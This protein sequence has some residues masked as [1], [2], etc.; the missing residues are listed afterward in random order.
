[1]LEKAYSQKGVHI[2]GN[3]NGW[4][5]IAPDQFLPIFIIATLVLIFGVAYAAIITL[6]KMKY[7][8]KKW[9]PLGYGFW[10][11]QTLSLYKLAILIHSNHYTTKVLL[12]TMVAYLFVPHLYFFLISESDKRYEQSDNKDS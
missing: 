4:P 1:M 3:V 10:G 12:V 9:A 6:V 2:M 7:L 5:E 8:S 11:L